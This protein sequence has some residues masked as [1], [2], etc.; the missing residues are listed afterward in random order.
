[1]S[2]SFTGINNIKISEKEYS[3]YG[4]YQKLNKQ[5]GQGEKNFT[6]IK[7]SAQLTDDKKGKDLSDYIK[8]TPNRFINT[9]SPDSIELHVKRFDV[10]KE[11]VNQ[12]SFTLNGKDLILD[13]D[14]KLPVMTFLAR[15]T[16]ENAK[17][18]ELSQNQQKYLKIA[19]KSI[20]KE[21]VE[22]IETR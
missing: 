4:L 5:I 17:N 21:A 15:L 7:I 3:A 1:M 20:H 14:R 22:Y 10:P 11:K 6:E 8:R 18:P 16:R 12:S 19:N 2:I 9:N 13:D